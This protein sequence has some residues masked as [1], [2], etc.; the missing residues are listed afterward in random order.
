MEGIEDRMETEIQERKKEKEEMYK[1]FE[2]VKYDTAINLFYFTINTI[3]F[4][5]LK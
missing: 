2:Q 4:W 5:V 3:S 1:D